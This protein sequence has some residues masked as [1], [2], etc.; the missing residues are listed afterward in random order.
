M[1]ACSP[2]EE[3]RVADARRY[4]GGRVVKIVP[5]WFPSFGYGT[6]I[7]RY[8][9]FY[10]RRIHR[11]IR[12]RASARVISRSGIR[13]IGRVP[14]VSPRVAARCVYSI[15]INN[16]H[17]SRIRPVHQ[18]GK[19]SYNIFYPSV[20]LEVSYNAEPPQKFIIRA[21]QSVPCDLLAIKS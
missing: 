15:V 5:P 21:I 14:R 8:S 9:A 7:S 11:R 6:I 18:V 20:F 1:N 19:D 3:E 13:S 17:E 4:F 16:V 12:A 2:V 10:V